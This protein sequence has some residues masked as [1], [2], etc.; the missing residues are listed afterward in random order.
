MALTAETTYRDLRAS[1]QN[2]KERRIR[3]YRAKV[4]KT[5]SMKTMG[6]FASATEPLRLIAQ[7]DSWFDYPLPVYPIRTDVIAHLESL[8]SMSPHVL[9]LAVLGEAAEDLLGV[10]KLHEL[11]DNL[12]DPANGGF[13]GILFSGGG[14]DL[15]GNQFRL[16]LQDA[17][18][19]GT[20]P[21]NGLNQGRVDDILGVI[22]AAYQDLFLARDHAAPGVPIFGHSYDFAIPNG[23]SVCGVGPWLQPGFADRGWT[24][25][26]VARQIVRLL[27]EQFAAMLDRFDAYAPNHFVHVRTQGTL[28]DNQWANELHPTPDGFAAIAARFVVAMRAPGN[29]PG[30]I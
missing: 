29:F 4:T 16:W 27:L 9:D 3:E 2:E 21:A 6:I 15:A 18:G 20:N 12:V 8:P 13:D 23:A 11:I 26:T 25:L 22:E 28:S 7:G 14:N 1:I 30:R 5:Q 19:G 17:T 10:V 24:D